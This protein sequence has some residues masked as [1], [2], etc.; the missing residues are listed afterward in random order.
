M[1][2]TTSV[3][4]PAT[5]STP[6][7]AEWGGVLGL[8]AIVVAIAFYLLVRF[9]KGVQS[10][11]FLSDLVK[12]PTR[13]AYQFA[14][15][16]LARRMEF[17][18]LYAQFVTAVVFVAVVA[19]LMLVNAIP[20]QA[21]LPA[22]STV[23]GIVLGKT[24]LNA[25]GTPLTAQ[26]SG[27]GGLANLTPPSIGGSEGGVAPASALTADPGEWSG[28]LPIQFSYAWTR[29]GAGG[30]DAIEDATAATYT[31][32]DADRGTS[33]RVVVTAS[34]PSGKATA[35]SDPVAIPE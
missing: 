13:A 20:D 26:E 3:P 30:V 23:I 29:A 11:S 7:T 34:G 6:T 35:T 10:S 28:Q 24:L 19:A 25:K 2:A 17:W 4:A 33:L 18:L 8:I 31:V 1:P 14:E 9:Y 12:K 22:L 32:V 5:S 16:V 21:G 15:E 27:A